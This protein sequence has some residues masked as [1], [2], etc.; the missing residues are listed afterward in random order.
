MHRP[1]YSFVAAIAA[2][3]VASSAAQAEDTFYLNVADIDLIHVLAPPPATGSPAA[4]ADLQAVLAAVASRTDAVV[5][6]VQADDER[7]VFRFTDVMGPDFSPEKLPF[8]A[9]FF[10]RVYTDGNIA[11]LVAKNYFKRQRPFVV[12]P[13]IRI[14]VAQKPDFSYPSNHSTFAYEVAILLA[15]MVPEKG[16]A[17]FNRAADYSYDRVIAGVHFPT[18]VE[19]GRIS[20]SIIDNTLLHDSRFLADFEHA[21]SEVRTTLGLNVAGPQ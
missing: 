7:V 5:K 2:V 11:T 21:K 19:A 3:V 4:R 6:H 17:L 9:R 20:G 8:A 18:D 14:I 10:Q 1:R 16:G 13:D 15:A 12:D